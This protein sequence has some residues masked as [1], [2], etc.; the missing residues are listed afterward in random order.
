MAGAVW[1]KYVGIPACII[2]SASVLSVVQSKPLPIQDSIS[3]KMTFVNKH[4]VKRWPTAGMNNFDGGGHSTVIWTR[5]TYIEGLMALYRTT[6]DTA[7][8]NYAVRWGSFAYTANGAWCGRGS[9]SASNADDQCCGQG[10]IEL[11]LCDTAQTVRQ[12]F[13]ATN[14]ANILTSAAVNYWTW[15]DALHMAMPVWAK[16][17]VI[18]KDTRYF[19]RMYNLYNYTKASIKCYDT[20]THLW[21]RDI[22]FVPPVAAAYATPHGL[23]CYWSRG[24]GWIMMALV[25]VLDVLPATDTH[26]AEYIKIVQ[27]MAAALKPIQRA[28][29][30]WNVDLG[31]SANY[32]GPE[33]TGTS[34]F[35]YGI[36]W[37]INHGILDSATYK[38]VVTR[39]WT[40]M[41]DSCIHPM[42]DTV[43]LGFVQGSGDRPS[44]SQPVTYARQ[45]NFDDYA[46]GALLLA[47][48]EVYKLAPATSVAVV[49]AI[50]HH[51]SGALGHN[52]VL[53]VFMANGCR[54]IHQT[55]EASATKDQLINAVS[56]TLARGYYTYR[57]NSVDAKIT[58]TGKLVK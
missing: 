23:N 16:L 45:P 57:M 22:N 13:I 3:A 26:R 36:A 6:L 20:T 48:S 12:A 55:F 47:G 33:I 40:G 25:R 49:P 2:I 43:V 37:G 50:A 9:L 54:I 8:Y 53:E 34:M 30:F 15:V 10:F 38:P 5:A 21:F 41:M 46:V 11:Y 51:V 31:D 24:N 39:A 14:F 56:K 19:D 27:E 29:G 44:S 52:G 17:G 58:I 7:C 28:D 18:K 32:P 35:T 1:L 4:F 42:A